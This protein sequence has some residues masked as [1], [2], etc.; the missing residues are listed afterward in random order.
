MKKQIFAFVL[1]VILITAF[2]SCTNVPS[3]GKSSGEALPI[4]AG[5]T[6]EYV[7][8]RS[9]LLATTNPVVKSTLALRSAIRTVTGAEIS[10]KTDWDGKE[11]NA[12]RKEILIG[13]T[14][15]PESAD[16]IAALDDG[17]FTVNVCGDGTKIVVTGKNER[18]TQAAVQYFLA[19][20]LKYNS[21]D[22]FTAN[23]DF[24]LTKGLSD[25]Q[26][27]T[28]SAGTVIAAGSAAEKKIISKEAGALSNG[29][30]TLERTDVLVYKLTGREGGGF[31]LALELEGE[32]LVT[33]STDDETYYRLFAYTD[34]GFGAARGS[35][36]ADLTP[37]F[38]SS[39][40]VYIRITDYHPLDGNSPVIYALTLTE[41]E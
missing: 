33:A 30:R 32:Y 14:N 40:T 23:P 35:Y 4:I 20:Y 9:D 15:R 29:A 36:S 13:D 19:A 39:D 28:G 10:I 34:D 12:Q 37:Y 11:D 2:T 7:I 18:S 27:Y 1:T 5:G 3:G 24:S 6:T 26:I 25:T 22:D 16:V 31:T 8:V 38:A 41:T 17:Q 21:D